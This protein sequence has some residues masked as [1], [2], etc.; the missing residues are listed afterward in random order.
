MDTKFKFRTIVY[1]VV[2]L[3]VLSV[4]SITCHFLGIERI[5]D[6]FTDIN[7]FD[8][9][10]G[11]VANTLIVLSLTSVL[12]SNFGQVY[13]VD[14]KDTKLISPFWGWLIK[15]KMSFFK[16]YA[17][18]KLIS[19]SGKLDAIQNLLLI[20]DP[21]N[22]GMSK[23][24]PSIKAIT[25]QSN[26]IKKQ[27]LELDNEL[28]KVKSEN[29]RTCM[30]IQCEARTNLKNKDTKL[31]Q[32]LQDI[33]K[34]ITP[35]DIRAYYV[36]IQEAH[37][38]YNEG[39]YEIVNKYLT[40]ILTNFEQD[41]FMIKSELGFTNIDMPIEYVFSYITDEE[42]LLIDQLIEKDMGIMAIPE[43]TKIKLSK[44][45][46]VVINNNVWSGISTDTLEIYRSTLDL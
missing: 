28:T 27:R 9:L 32:D 19:Q 10:T 20:Y 34:K 30:K 36:P 22:L 26:E 42:K 33:L 37:L 2:T 25:E 15:D 1:I 24:M 35:K 44:L 12:S 43:A 3:V 16:Q 29:Y 8:L 4:T 7:Y 6:G 39:K 38:A 46:R 13:W 31:G 14:I 45:N 21:T 18:Q 5:L 17:L 40:V 11:Q 41:C 23:L